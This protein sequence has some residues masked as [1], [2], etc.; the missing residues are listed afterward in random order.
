M[1]WI[2]F[3]L[4]SAYIYVVKFAF[5]WSPAYGLIVFYALKIAYSLVIYAL[6]PEDHFFCQDYIFS[7][8]YML[9]VYALNISFCYLYW[10]SMFYAQ[11]TVFPFDNR[12]EDRF[13]SSAYILVVYALKIVFFLC[14]YFVCLCPE[15]SSLF[16]VYCLVVCTLSTYILE[17]Y[18]FICPLIIF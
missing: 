2:S 17:V 12:C 15:G 5:Y 3:Y 14:L 6:H 13:L 1:S 8:T 7:S 16:S 9:I 4:S 10:L 11:K 18:H